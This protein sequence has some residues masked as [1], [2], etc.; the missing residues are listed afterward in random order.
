VNILAGPGAPP[1]RELARLGVAR[2]SLGSGVAEA[3]YAVMQR[4]VTEALTDGTY[5]AVADGIAYGELNDLM[6][7]RTA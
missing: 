4:A 5:T 1:V 3:A 6:A 7:R 2:V